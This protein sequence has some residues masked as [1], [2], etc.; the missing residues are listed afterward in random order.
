MKGPDIKI[1]KNL[2]KQN[3]ISNYIYWYEDKSLDDFIDFLSTA[4]L[5]CDQFGDSFQGMVTTLAFALGR[6]VMAKFVKFKGFP[7]FPGLNVN[8]VD[9]VTQGLFF[10]SN[11]RRHLDEIGK[12][13]RLF[14]EIILSPILNGGGKSATILSASAL[15]ILLEI[16]VLAIPIGN[17]CGWNL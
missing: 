6:P 8:S 7:I 13:S 9:D 17:N 15:V 10:A 4:D 2:I 14:A 11:N 3:D 12:Q 1:I 5:V 16:S